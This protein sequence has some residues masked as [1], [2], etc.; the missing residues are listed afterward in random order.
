MPIN[1]LDLQTNFSHI[2]QVGKS[3]SNIKESEELKESQL[4]NLIHKESENEADDIPIT[5]D[6]SE[7]PG[8]I[9]DEEKNNNPKNQKKKVKS[10]TNQEEN[11]ESEENTEQVLKNPQL[12]QRI[13]IVG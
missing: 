13:D 3:V 9:K 4:A 6:L 1:P 2:N 5:K 7:G 8:K 12:G 11:E 10:N